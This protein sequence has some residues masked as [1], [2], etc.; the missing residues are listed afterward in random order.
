[1]KPKPG[2]VT[3]ENTEEKGLVQVGLQWN[4]NHF[5]ASRRRIP[6]TRRHGNLNHAKKGKKWI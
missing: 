5:R 4:G 2:K 1:M 3:T 6:D